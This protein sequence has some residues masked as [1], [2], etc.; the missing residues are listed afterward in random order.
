ME[1]DTRDNPP[2]TQRP[3][4]LAIKHVEWVRQEIEALEKLKF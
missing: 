4:S 1:I 3:Y 2:F